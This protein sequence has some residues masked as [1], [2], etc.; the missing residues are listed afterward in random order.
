MLINYIAGTEDL[1]KGKTMRNKSKKTGKALDLVNYRRVLYASLLAV[2]LPACNQSLTME[3]QT[4][5]PTPLSIQLPLSMAVV[6][7]DEFRNY[8]YQENSEDRPNW[9]IKSGDSQVELFDRVLPS[10]FSEISYQADVPSANGSGVDGVLVPKVEEMQFALPSETRSDLYEVWIKYTVKLFDDK[11]DLVA[12]LPV[13]GY[14]KSSTEFLKSR[15]KGLQAAINSAFRD[16]G[17]KLSLNFT[18]IPPVRQWL[19]ENDKVCASKVT[20]IC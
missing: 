4:D 16:A 8:I 13:T 12:D 9:A 20:D 11:G 15:D 17:A 3:T 6:Y 18:R 14:G 7:D 1:D 19:S 5:V 2:V 10:M